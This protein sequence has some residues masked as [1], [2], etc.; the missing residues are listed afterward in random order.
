MGIAASCCNSA[1]P[2]KKT[3]M[4]V[5]FSLDSELIDKDIKPNLDNNK[6]QDI[7]SANNIEDAFN[8]ITSE[9]Y[10]KLLFKISYPYIII[11]KI[12]QNLENSDLLS[13]LQ[14]LLELCLNYH[15]VSNKYIDYVKINLDYGTKNTFHEINLLNLESINQNNSF[16]KLFIKILSDLSLIYQYFKYENEKDNNEDYKENYWKDLKIEEELKTYVYKIDYNLIKLK[17]DFISVLSP[18]N[19]EFATSSKTCEETNNK[20]KIH[21]RDITIKIY[22]DVE[23]F[24]NNI[25]KL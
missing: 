21:T 1:D 11:G 6:L 10:Y 14:K 22:K 8:F 2:N 24:V 13:L 18:L 25:S 3:E 9:N 20:E 17:N 12:I 15:N 5:S 19:N 23:N 7:I 16:K 4:I